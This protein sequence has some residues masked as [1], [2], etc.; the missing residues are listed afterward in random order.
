MRN[1]DGESSREPL[2]LK[3]LKSAF[4]MTIK[5]TEMIH[6]HSAVYEPIISQIMQSPRI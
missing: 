1:N 3:L 4:K 6:N 2:A 5:G